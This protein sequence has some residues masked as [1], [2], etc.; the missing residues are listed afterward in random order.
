[1]SRKLKQTQLG[2]SSKKRP[3]P[4]AVGDPVKKRAR[5]DSS[6]SDV[7]KENHLPRALREQ[8]EGC[9]E[10]GTPPHLASSEDGLS[11]ESVSAISGRFSCEDVSAFGAHAL[12]CSS[13]LTNSKLPCTKP[14][15]TF[16][17][18]IHKDII[19]H[20]LAVEIIDTPEFQRLRSLA[21]LGV[22]HF[23]FHC[24]NH[25][26][27]Q[28]SLG[29]YHLSGKMIDNV[30]AKQTLPITPTDKLCVQIAGLC[31][32]MGHGPWSHVWDG[33]FIPKVAKHK[34]WEH[35][36]GSVMMFEHM[37]ASNQIDTSKYGLEEI[38]LVFIKEIIQ[39]TK[40]KDRKGRPS[41]KWWL[42]DIVHNTD[43]GLD[44]DKLDYFQRDAY[45]AGVSVSI[46]FSYPL[47]QALVLP[48]PA[49]FNASRPRL[50]FPKK[51][52]DSLLELF[53]TR[54]ILHRKVYAHKSVVE[55][56]L[57]LV[58]MLIE[59]NPYLQL[60]GANV[61]ANPYLQLVGT[62]GKAVKLSET[63]DD[64]VAYAKLKDSL[65]DAIQDSPVKEMQRARQLLNR[66]ITRNLYVYISKIEVPDH[67]CVKEDGLSPKCKYCKDEEEVAQE[68]AAC[69]PA[70]T[71]Q[72]Q[73]IIISTRSIHYG[74]KEQCPVDFMWFYDKSSDIGQ[75]L[76][77]SELE[78]ILGRPERFMVKHMRVFTRHSQKEPE[79][80]RAVKEAFEVWCSTN[81]VE[82]QTLTQC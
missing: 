78:G 25:N 56:E 11:Q 31:H 4:L 76:T 79:K 81:D 80:V 55:V 64:P 15:K 33:Q 24:A 75:K 77:P 1:M 2:F 46:D 14:S 70:G 7:L 43:S 9:D 63:I 68:I 19:M 17:D 73:D 52:V 72:P 59:A 62:N 61:K 16:W 26:R 58:D 28:H 3:I 67:R 48:C 49:P 44:V 50:C 22:A 82:E 47:S 45:H 40:E 54:F 13:T 65:M 32:D 21:Q 53:R 5:K 23:T 35:E 42:Y 12:V 74:K 8:E 57:M 30:M 38:D 18:T 20:P 10:I 66:I 6:P 60:V 34:H 27:F 71:T 37:L 36:Q 69:D 41:E 29:V 39:G 51:A